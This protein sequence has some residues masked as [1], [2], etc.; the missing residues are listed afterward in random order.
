MIEPLKQTDPDRYQL[1]YD[2]V[3]K[4]ECAYLYLQFDL[5][6]DI[7]EY[8]FIQ[9]YKRELYEIFTKHSLRKGEVVATES[10]FGY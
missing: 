6:P 7:F 5:Y 10:Y 9:N 4:E 1:I 3:Q 8:S 2:R